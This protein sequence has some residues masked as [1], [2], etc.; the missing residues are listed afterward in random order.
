MSEEQRDESLQTTLRAQGYRLTPQRQLVLPAVNELGHGTPDEIC[1]EVQRTAGGVNISTVYRT[2]ELLE[3]LG[4]VTH[5]TSVTARRRTIP[6]PRRTTFTWCAGSVARSSRRC[7]DRG[8]AHRRPG[9]PAR[10]SSATSPTLRSSVAARIVCH[11]QPVAWPPRSGAGRSARPGRRRALWR[12]LPRAATVRLGRRCR[13]PVTQTC[14]HGHRRRPARLAP[15]ADVA[16]RRGVACRSRDGG[17]ILSPQVHIEHHL[18]LVDDGETTW[19]HSSRARQR[20]S[21]A[22]S[23]R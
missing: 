5:R 19:M 18:S 22:I 10:T 15:L 2:L 6:H 8:P 21:S 16:A 7:L 17:T 4:L 20:H 9:Q 3:E 14:R 1:L 13:R 12:S 11:D 23:T